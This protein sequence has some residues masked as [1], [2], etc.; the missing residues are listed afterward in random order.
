MFWI[1]AVVALAVGVWLGMP[2][3]RTVSEEESLDAF[4]KGGGKRSVTKKAVVWVDYL[5][6]GKKKSRVR[7]RAQAQRKAFGN[8]VSTTATG[9][10]KGER[11]E[12][13]ES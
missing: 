4:E 8:L 9:S 5:F 11:S 3:D 13:A 10:G 1:F 12:S 2:G 7:A 6:R